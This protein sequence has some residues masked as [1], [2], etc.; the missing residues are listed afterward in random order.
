[1]LALHPDFFQK[2]FTIKPE[3]PIQG[4]P[5]GVLKPLSAYVAN[6][7]LYLVCTDSLDHQIVEVLA[8]WLV[9][10]VPPFEVV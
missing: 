5:I 10:V 3:V 9:E 1:M 4:G 6:N 2:T 8:I 7:N